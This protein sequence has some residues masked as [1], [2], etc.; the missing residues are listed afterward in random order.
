M[1]DHDDGVLESCSLSSRQEVV[2]LQCC[3]Q[4]ICVQGSGL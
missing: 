1:D 2:L 4:G 3:G